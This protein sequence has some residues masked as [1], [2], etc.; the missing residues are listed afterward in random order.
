MFPSE[1]TVRDHLKAVCAR[2]AVHSRR[3]LVARALGA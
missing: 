1:G 3:A 2:I